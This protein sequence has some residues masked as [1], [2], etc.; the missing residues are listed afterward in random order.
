MA[1]GG[2]GGGGNVA[3]QFRLG[4][5]NYNLDYK[6]AHPINFLL[7]PFPSRDEHRPHQTSDTIAAAGGPKISPVSFPVFQ[8]RSFLLLPRG[9]ERRRVGRAWC[10]RERASERACNNEEEEEEEEAA[11]AAAKNLRG[12]SIKISPPGCLTY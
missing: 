4:A 5:A 2:G 10:P 9:K 11:A 7:P 6:L 8:T 3:V 1:C 12:H